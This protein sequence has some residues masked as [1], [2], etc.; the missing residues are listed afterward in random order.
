MMI[1][2][3]L[4]IWMMLAVVVAFWLGPVLKEA[5]HRQFGKDPDEE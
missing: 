2:I 4:S 5:R 1:W 3:I